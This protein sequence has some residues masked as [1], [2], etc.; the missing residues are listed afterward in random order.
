MD[1]VVLHTDRLVLRAPTETDV[2][3]ITAACQD[4]EI[5]RWTTVPSPY[6]R[7]DAEDFVAFVAQAWNEGNEAVWGVYRDESLIACVGLHHITEHRAGGHAEL[8]YWTAPA[9][10]GHGYLSEAARAV[11]DWGFRDL[12]LAR[13]QWQAVEG[14]IP[15]ARTARGLGFRF[16]GTRRQALVSHRG[17]DDGWTAGLLSTDDRSPVDWPVDLG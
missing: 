6:S 8:G 10:R 12:G 3:A 9:A 4:P 14:N 17:R 5:P 2:D 7:K 11:V 1:S 15:S 16:E 13:I